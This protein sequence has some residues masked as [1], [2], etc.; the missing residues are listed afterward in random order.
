M[1]RLII[2]SNRVSAP[3]DSNSGAQGGLA[4]ALAAALRENGGIWFGW[5]GDVT[6]EFTGDINFQRRAGVTAAT[7]DLEQQDVEE[8][9]NG[10]ANRTLWPLF[11]YRIDL[12]EYERGFAGGYVRVN[13]RFADTVR[14]LIEPEDVV[15]IQDYHMFPLGQALRDRGCRNRIGF[16]LHIPWPPRRLLGTLPEAA[17]LVR[18]MFAYDVVGFHTEEWLESFRDFAVKDLGAELGEDNTLKLGDR[19][20]KA[21]AAPIGIDCKEFVEGANSP[22]ARLAFRQMR[23]SAV[24]R[25]MIVGVDRLDYSKGLEERFRGY[26]RFLERH[27]EER[28][29]VFLLQIAPP[30]R[31]G[32]E[33]YQKIRT[34]LEGLAGYIN[35][36]YADVDWVPIRYVNQGYPRDQ[37]AGIYRAARIGLVTPLRDGMNLVAK[38][39]VAAQ[40]P[41]NPGV[42][43]LSNFAGAAAQLREGAVL[44]NPYSAEEM[45][46]AIIQA[47]RMERQERI[48]RWRVMMDN[49]EKE[50]VIW[51]RK[52]FTSV[53][54]GT[55]QETEPAE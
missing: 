39:Y 51:W 15:W 24:G 49:V 9:Y 13:D 11:H 17:D 43:I 34:T 1:S 42:L 41:E 55:E 20:L 8:Y 33:S 21:I 25:D 10:Y 27:P 46:D 30:S 2:I 36:R 44:I 4:V 19:T 22:A 31:A 14:P 40:D 38:E 48:D 37:L 35:G 18:T 54:M 47:L 23:D 6:E 26:E 52:R 29:E 5:S 28:K 45:S 7:I 12:A 3:K 50:D 32:V 16:F 53:L